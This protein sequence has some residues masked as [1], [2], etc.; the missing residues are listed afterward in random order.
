MQ[1]KICEEIAP[2]KTKKRLWWILGG[3]VLV[4]ALVVCLCFGIRTAKS[5]ANQT[6]AAVESGDAQKIFQLMPE[7]V[8][9][10]GE[11]GQQ[12]LQEE[13]QNRLDVIRTASV[14]CTL[15]ENETV[16]TDNLDKLERYYSEYYHCT[17][18]IQKAVTYDLRVMVGGMPVQQ[19]IKLTMLKID[20]K[21]YADLFS[22]ENLLFVLED[23]IHPITLE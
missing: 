11:G 1:E 9:E 15:G 2:K 14:T 20:G 13:L 4:A 23:T 16:Q 10:T 12:I 3:V 8:L 19:T 21:W 5:T 22:L 18:K 17:L 6:L 7:A